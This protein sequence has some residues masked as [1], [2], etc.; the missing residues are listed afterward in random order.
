MTSVRFRD[1]LG[2]AIFHEPGRTANDS[3]SAKATY[4][5][6]DRSGVFVQRVGDFS[7]EMEGMDGLTYPQLSFGDSSSAHACELDNSPCCTDVVPSG[8][9][10]RREFPSEKGPVAFSRDETD[11]DDLDDEE[12]DM[13]DNDWDEM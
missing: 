6:S 2:S 7:R 4:R 11:E 9:S 3:R 5:Y 13:D 1:N 10:S 12:E 8:A